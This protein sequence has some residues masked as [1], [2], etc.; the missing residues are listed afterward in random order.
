MREIALF[1]RDGQLKGTTHVEPEFQSTPDYVSVEHVVY[2]AQGLGF[3]AGPEQYV[4]IEIMV[5][6]PATVT[7]P[8][9]P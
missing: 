1:G 5:I 6:D 8:T 2:R 3:T 9:A 7:P 4:E